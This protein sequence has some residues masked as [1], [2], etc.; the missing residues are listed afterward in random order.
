M[1]KIVLAISV[2][3]IVLPNSVAEPF[4]L[5]IAGSMIKVKSDFTAINQVT[6]NDYISIDLAKD[7]SESFQLVLFPKGHD[8]SN[9]K[10]EFSGFTPL[11]Q[12][13]HFRCHKVGYVK[14]ANPTYGVEHVGWWPDPLLPIEKIT[15][16][17]SNVQPL[18]CSFIT[19]PETHSGVYCGILKVSSGKNSQKITIIV[20]VRKFTIPRPGSFEA[21]FGLYKFAI[22]DWYFGKPGTM[23]IKNFKKWAEMAGEYRLTPK[24]IGTEFVEQT[25]ITDGGIKQLT[26]VNMS[27][28]NSILPELTKKYYPDYTYELFRLPAA[29]GMEEQAKKGILISPKMFTEFSMKYLSEWKKQG[30]TDKTYIYGIDEP[31][32]NEMKEYCG[33]VYRLLKKTNPSIKIMQ[34]GNCNIPELIGLV[35]I[36]C[37]KSNIAWDPFFQERVKAG[38]KLWQYV[39]ISPNPPYANFFVD[40]PGVDHRNLFWQTRKIDASGMLYW[41]VFW[42]NKLKNKAYE[43]K[44]TFPDIPFDFTQS[45]FYTDEWCHANG[46]GMMMYPGH[47]LTPLS[48]I[49][50]EIIRDGIEDYE[51][52]VILDKLIK[53]IDEI[54]AYKSKGAQNLL[55]TARKLSKVPDNIVKSATTYT[56]DPQMILSYRKQLADMIEQLMNIKE[57]KD[58]ERWH[59]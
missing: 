56:K 6:F 12:S 15:V 49:R 57:N 59:K 34:T 2:L 37:P 52:F 30:F 38:D 24:N 45:Q 7:E 27:A 51:Y 33:D 25:Y 23:N 16:P 5:G 17:K 40:E 32:S 10:I 55:N 11:E 54:P 47:K 42:V 36:W 18:W 53:E 28:L 3:F 29:P 4:R 50:L 1:K 9:I 8:L 58:Y 21:P 22:E 41:T 26:S 39:C 44:I 13:I 46:D 19:K 43:G 48:S 14:T 31:V 20:N 35:D